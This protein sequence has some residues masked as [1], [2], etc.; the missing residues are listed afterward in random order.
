[1]NILTIKNRIKNLKSAFS[2]GAKKA[3]AKEEEEKKAEEDEKGE[4]NANAENTDEHPKTESNANL[5]SVD[6][7]KGALGRRKSFIKTARHG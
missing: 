5:L 4:E 1:M 2:G 7:A 6:G 3:A